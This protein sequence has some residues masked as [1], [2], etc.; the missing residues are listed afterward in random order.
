MNALQM[1]SQAN[2]DDHSGNAQF[3]KEIVKCYKNSIANS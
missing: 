2:E 1:G 3:W